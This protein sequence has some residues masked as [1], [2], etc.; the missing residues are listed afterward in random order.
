MSKRSNSNSQLS[1]EQVDALND[2][3]EEEDAGVFEKAPEEE[4]R[5][6]K[7]VRVKRPNS[8]TG[9]DSSLSQNT[10]KSNHNNNPFGS[11]TFSLTGST[12]TVG[13]SD[14]TGI[15]STT[16]VNPFASF[17][18]LV[19]KP[20]SSAA[21]GG[22]SSSLPA[23]SSF[24]G[25]GFSFNAGV[26]SSSAT[27]TTASTGLTSF[28][29]GFSSVNSTGSLGSS[30]SLPSIQTI[31]SNGNSTISTTANS[32]SNETSEYNRKMKK[33]NAAFLSWAEKQMKTNVM[34]IWKEG[35]KDYLSHQKKLREKYPQEEVVMKTEESNGGGGST[36]SGVLS[37][38]KGPTPSTDNLVSATSGSGSGSGGDA[39]T[40]T[41]GFVF[42]ASAST[43]SG[44]STTSSAAG[45]KPAF[46]FGS[47]PSSSSANSA[48]EAP[49]P[50][51][52]GNSSGNSNAFSFAPTSSAPAVPPA[53]PSTSFFSSTST[54]GA[55][56]SSFSFT[57]KP[58]APFSATSAPSSG[59]SLGNSTPGPH[60]IG[61]GSFG[62]GATKSGGEHD[63]DEGGGDDEGEPILEPE[64]ILRNSD[65]KDEILL[66][67]PCKLF[68]YNREDSEWKDLGKGCFRLTMDPSTKK[69]RMM[70]RNTLGRITFNA[71]FYKGMKIDRVKGGLRFNAVV[72]V[73]KNVKEGT[74]ETELKSFMVKLKDVDIE[75]VKNELEAAI[76]AM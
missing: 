10:I 52:F 43:S 63:N 35:V 41:Q 42:G 30:S 13:Q 6:R 73:V 62:L 69:K 28:S 37:S 27:I 22:S 76:A 16:K 61:A 19:A 1:K 60:S 67:V 34:T 7:I 59:F 44:N 2:D 75:N 49:K 8:M 74:S 23:T 11:S 18:G 47:T 25:S 14:Q 46:A 4:I 20:T 58:F 54:T 3:D 17:Q 55:P 29:T 72:A 40:T 9:G 65:D 36:T 26:P 39:K 15:E 12:T 57:P 21:V 68:S 45:V 48:A 31:S 70:V 24:V 50:F 38:N 66:D 32:G 51:A 56:A 71:N 53:L 33:L 64:K 5:Q